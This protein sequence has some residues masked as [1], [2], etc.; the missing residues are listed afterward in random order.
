MNPEQLS[1]ILDEASKCAKSRNDKAEAI[2][3]AN[4]LFTTGLAAVP[5][6]INVWPFVGSNVA[7][8][9]GLGHLYGFNTDREQA[10]ALMWQIFT[11]GS[12][13]SSGSFLIVKFFSEVLKI[14]FPLGW[15][16]LTPF[17]VAGIAL[18]ALLQGAVS[19]ALGY[20]AKTYFSRGCT[21]EKAE[22]RKEFGARLEEGKAKVAAARKAKGT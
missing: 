8:I 21:L 11:A 14:T 13:T 18:D 1:T 3:W 15:I 16:P 19:Y 20:T 10:G 2:I 22:M 7:C 4:V 9:I 5:F 6:G 17:M 12:W